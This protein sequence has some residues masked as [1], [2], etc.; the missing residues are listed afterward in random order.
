MVFFMSGPQ[1]GELEAGIAAT[2]IGAPLAVVTGG[3]G[4]I[5]AVAWIAARTPALRGYR[6]QETEM[7]AQGVAAD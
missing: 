7:A 5:L 6:K 4:C 3:L 2:L 1:L